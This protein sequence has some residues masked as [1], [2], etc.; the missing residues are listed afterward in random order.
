MSFFRYRACN[1]AGE[2]LTGAAEAEN[3]TALENRLRATGLWLLE[4]HES[5]AAQTDANEVSSATVRR[6]DLIT[7]FIQMA[8]LLRAGIPLAQALERLAIDF[9][10][11]SLGP[12]LD[13]LY[14]S[15]S[16]G[17]PLNRSMERY[18]KVFS[19][20]AVSMV[21]AGEA[22]GQLPQVFDHL[23][24]YYEWLDQLVSDIRQALIYPL[25]VMGAATALIILLFTF[26]VPKFVILLTDL[27]L[28]IPTLTRVV[29]A[30]SHALI[31]GWPWFLAVF[32]GVPL[33]LKFA[34]RRSPEFARG[35]DEHLMKLPIFGS[36]IAMFALSRFTQN[37]SMLYKAG[38]PLLRGLEISRNLVGN[39]AIAA[40][41]DDARDGVSQGVPLSKGLAR[42]A[43]FPPMLIT[44][45]ATGES[46]GSLDV[47][48]QGIADY[49][50]KMIPRRIKI[51]F[52]IFDP[53]M[54]LSLI[55]VVGVVALSVILPILKLWTVR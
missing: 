55:G 2:N 43:L 50:N 42:H 46:S 44:M 38:V 48:L 34:L 12:V 31:H 40:A 5:K 30:V 13:H 28:E 7:F 18:P 11:T 52:A 8:L 9:T 54:M 39:H 35:F 33:A 41:I 4:A 23:S 19:R 10:H 16:V 36:L 24:A 51:V 25:M 26:V 37:L 22:S 49:Y 21:Q 27:K 29:M 3:L 1:S 45:I 15:I 53:L 6:A 32:V 20:Q 47:A 17:N 14:E